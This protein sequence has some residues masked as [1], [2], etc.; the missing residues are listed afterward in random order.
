MYHKSMKNQ[1]NVF[2]LRQ[3]SISM[4]MLS[5]PK[6]MKYFNYISIQFKF[7]ATSIVQNDHMWQ[8]NTINTHYYSKLY[9]LL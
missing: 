9:M 3:L 1:T 7:K 2:D 8:F 6:H 5:S 4:G